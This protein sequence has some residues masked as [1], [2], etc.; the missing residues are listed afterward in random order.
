MSLQAEGPAD[1]KGA[2]PAPGDEDICL[3]SPHLACSGEAGVSP[4]KTADLSLLLLSSESF[5][6]PW[7]I[8]IN[9][10]QGLLGQQKARGTEPTE[11]RAVSFDLEG[12]VKA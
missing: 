3:E 9:Q 5:P 7:R 6:T 1:S 11:Q 10:Q 4:S 12:P 2:G 8:G